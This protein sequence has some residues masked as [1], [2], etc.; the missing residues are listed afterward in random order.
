LI[1]AAA[2]AATLSGLAR[3]LCRP[4]GKAQSEDR[5]FLE[6]TLLP[7]LDADVTIERLLF[8]GCAAY[9]RHYPRIVG[10]TEF[11]TLEPQPRRAHHGA[12]LHIVD[13]LQRLPCHVP[14]A[15]FDAIVVNG[16]LGWGLNRRDDAEAALSACHAALRPGGL[17]ILGWN[18]VVPR[19]GIPPA[20]LVALNRFAPG[21]LEAFPPR[22]QMPGP[23]C[24]V[25]E[26][27]RR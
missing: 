22:L 20:T 19:N 23:E 24:H 10:H 6:N 12:S 26:F 2:L 18:D 14:P 7:T 5:R 21:G 4:F 9:T 13:T 27:Y 8:V 16:V 3:S 15:H 11:W 17:L 25:F 1:G